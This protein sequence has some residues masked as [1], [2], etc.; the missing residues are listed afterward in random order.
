MKQLEI[1]TEQKEFF[2]ENGYLILEKVIENSDLQDV[3]DELNSE[4]DKRAKDLFAEG[5]IS[6]LYAN[7]PFETRLAKISAE[8]PKL[9]VSIW[10]GILHGPA[11]FELI[12]NPK[13]LDVA[14][15][16][17][18]EELIASSVYRLRPKIPNY[19][20]GEVPWHQDSGYFE[21][22]C[23]DSLVMTMWIPLVDTNAD[24]GCLFVIPGTH[25][26]NVVE[27]EMHKTGKYL[28]V[29]EELVPK[30]NWVECAV[31]KGGLLLLSNKVIHASF[32]NKTQG[33]RW[34]MDLR[35]QSASLPTNAE[36][37]KTE[38]ASK[39]NIN[40]DVPS[41]CYPPDADF[42]VRSKTRK[43]EVVNSY[44]AFKKLRETFVGKPVTNRFGVT[45]TELKV[46][47]VN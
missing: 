4:I 35:Y 15:T 10:N 7:E 40:P 26:G 9:A 12:S 21:P 13:L 32:K 43:D 30:E 37:T 6:D 14:E 36:I 8:T 42:L 23:D 25:K 44:E 16:F 39:K 2:K 20:Y 45:W 1:S 27:H 29:K 41:A 11:I 22:Y 47:E 33:V 5:E 18:G 46:D 34:S 31:P 3:I 19:G 38:E 24:N 17:C 28:A